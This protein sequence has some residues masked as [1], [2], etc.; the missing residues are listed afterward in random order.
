MIKK[1]INYFVEY[2][3]KNK[4]NN[5]WVRCISCQETLEFAKERAKILGLKEYRIIEVTEEITTNEK[6]VFEN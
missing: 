6:C 5:E 2:K 1:C 3:Q 4:Q